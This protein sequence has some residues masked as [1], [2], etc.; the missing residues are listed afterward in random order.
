[1][2]LFG[3]I[4][5]F[6]I[7]FLFLVDCFGATFG[8]T[9]FSLSFREPPVSCSLLRHRH[10][11]RP[12]SFSNHDEDGNPSTIALLPSVIFIGMVQWQKC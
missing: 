1:M 11:F 9:S 2:F 5:I 3:K 4:S 7:D 10:P 8:T 12:A 6:R